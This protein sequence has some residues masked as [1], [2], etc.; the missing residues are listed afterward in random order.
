MKYE[1]HHA[2]EEH[3][4]KHLKSAKNTKAGY[5]SAAHMKRSK[6]ERGRSASESI[7]QS[8][9]CSVNEAVESTQVLAGKTG[10]NISISRQSISVQHELKPAKRAEVLQHKS[11]FTVLLQTEESKDH[12]TSPVSSCRTEAQPLRLF[13]FN[14]PWTTQV[15]HQQIPPSVPDQK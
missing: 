12:R 4:S 8:A 11:S 13:S 3:P 6:Q 1:L 10:P 5:C 15:L 2:P 9:D 7:S 14:S